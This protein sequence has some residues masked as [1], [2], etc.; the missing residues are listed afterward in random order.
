MRTLGRGPTGHLFPRSSCIETLRSAERVGRVARREPLAS[1]NT[2]VT[3]EFP[4]RPVRGR[5]PIDP[6]ELQRCFCRARRA[7][8]MTIISTC[9][10]MPTALMM[11]YRK[12]KIERHDLANR[13]C[14]AKRRLAPIEQVRA[15]VRIDAMMDLLG[16]LPHQEYAAG[17]RIKSHQ[18]KSCPNRR[19]RGVV[20]ETMIAM[21]ASNAKRRITATAMPTRRVACRWFSGSLLVR[22]AMKTRLSMPK[23]DLHGDQSYECDPCGGVH[24]K[25]QQGVHGLGFFVVVC[26]AGPKLY[27]PG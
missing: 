24:G 8:T 21:A 27:E 7:N 25:A 4:Q 5:L 19:N 12:H 11:L 6:R 16:C 26:S 18:E 23:N 13:C 9:G 3:N 17:E 14:E 10:V 2:P 1:R 15:G 22:M 20:S